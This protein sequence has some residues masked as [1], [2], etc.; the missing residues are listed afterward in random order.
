MS[1]KS[2]DYKKIGTFFVTTQP[3]KTKREDAEEHFMDA[4]NVFY[5]P[6]WPDIEL[7]CNCSLKTLTGTLSRERK[8]GTDQNSLKTLTF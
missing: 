7:N 1:R 8:V 4:S 2:I 5:M 3:E 6:Q